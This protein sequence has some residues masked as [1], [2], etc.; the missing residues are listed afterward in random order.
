MKKVTILAFILFGAMTFTFAQKTKDDT[1]S[2][3]STGLNKD[4]KPDMRLKVNKDKAKATTT[5]TTTTTTPTTTT[6]TVQPKSTKTTVTTTVPTTSTKTA[7]KTADK[8]IGTDSKGRTIYEGP[9]GGHYYINSKGNKEYISK[10]KGT[11]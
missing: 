7:V 6:T 8:T 3:K 9:R 4:G 2:H 1:K 10:D 5:T 11:K